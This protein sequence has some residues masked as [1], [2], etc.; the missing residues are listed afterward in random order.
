MS[1]S[2]TQER[3]YEYGN[4]HGYDGIDMHED[5]DANTK[6]KER[7][8]YSRTGACMLASA[9]VH[10]MGT[11]ARKCRQPQKVLGN[12]TVQGE[13]RG[14]INQRHKIYKPRHSRK[15]TNNYRLGDL[16]PD[17]IIVGMGS[18]LACTCVLPSWETNLYLVQR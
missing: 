12:D 14:E 3:I 8:R 11:E 7:H 4:E 5:M 2:G 13:E 6:I 9:V 1:G 16:T 15:P 18:A 10:L 17:I